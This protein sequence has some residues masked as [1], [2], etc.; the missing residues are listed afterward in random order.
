MTLRK[1][2]ID[3]S[4][5]YIPRSQQTRE[6]EIKPKTK[7]AGS[8]PLKQIKIISKNNEKFP[9]MWQQEDLLHLQNI[10]CTNIIIKFCILYILYIVFCIY[11]VYFVYYN[12]KINYFVIRI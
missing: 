8:L 3:N 1:I 5:R 6:R 10:I 11:F 12:Y 2:T 9:K 4:V 7:K